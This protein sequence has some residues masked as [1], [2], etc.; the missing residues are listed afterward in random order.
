VD[1]A[2]LLT[3]LL[4]RAGFWL[5]RQWRPTAECAEDYKALHC[6]V[7]LDKEGW[8]CVRPSCVVQVLDSVHALLGL[9]RLL[10]K[11]QVVSL[12][13][14]AAAGA[15]V[16]EAVRL[17]NHHREASIDEFYEMSMV[18]DCM[19]SAVAQY[20]HR[21]EFLFHSISQVVYY[22]FP[23]YER[24]WQQQMQFLEEYAAP[25]VN[26]L[27]LLLQVDPNLPFFYEHTCAGLLLAYS[28]HAHSWAFMSG[29][30][31]LVDRAGEVFC[32]EDLRSLLL[33]AGRGGASAAA[34]PALTAV[35]GALSLAPPPAGAPAG[36]PA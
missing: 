28:A 26:L 22:H 1:Y 7:D 2:Q 36:A 5:A 4:K 25:G 12:H 35:V 6:L 11:A 27:P 15:E 32:A 20:L 29:Y 13:A 10:M 14:P 31:L 19:V 21:F 16:D 34:A 8:R 24:Q 3:A 23:T 18:A 30:I 9:T 17:Y 33:F